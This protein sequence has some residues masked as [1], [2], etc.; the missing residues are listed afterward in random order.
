M[1]LHKKTIICM[2][3]LS[4]VSIIMS[5]FIELKVICIKNHEQYIA[6][7]LMGIFASGILIL[8]SSVI[9]FTIEK[10]KFYLLCYIELNKLLANVIE[11][12]RVM[13][14]NIQGAK[15][16]E[17]FKEIKISFQN[18]HLTLGEYTCF[19]KQDK[20]IPKIKNIL[21]ATL[22]FCKIHELLDKAN[23]DLSIHEINMAEYTTAFETIKNEMVN[24]HKQKFVGY[25]KEILN[26]HQKSIDKNRAYKD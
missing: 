20:R 16:S 24:E 1:K 26:L 25:Q 17:Y 18:L 13:E 4:L 2:L 9:A 5:L 6:N 3:I 14:F 21:E 8:I 15:T 7:I 10:N 23:Y 12:I 19:F 11:I 22:I